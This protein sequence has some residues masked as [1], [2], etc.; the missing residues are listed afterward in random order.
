MISILLFS[1]FALVFLVPCTRPWPHCCLP[2]LP[3]SIRTLKT[4]SGYTVLL[5][6][7]QIC[8]C[9]L[10]LVNSTLKSNM[11]LTDALYSCLFVQKKIYV[12]F[13]SYI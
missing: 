3:N 5:S 10:H 13:V 2:G 1:Y 12:F 11:L 9:S 4:A 6:N 8:T 7:I